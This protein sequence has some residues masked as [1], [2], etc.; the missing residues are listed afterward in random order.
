MELKEIHKD[1]ARME[2]QAVFVDYRRHPAL[3]A[4][5]KI[6]KCIRSLVHI[7]QAEVVRRMLALYMR[8]DGAFG[9]QGLIKM[10]VGR[11]DMLQAGPHSCDPIGWEMSDAYE[12][13]KVS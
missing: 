1:L 5:E 7:D 6:E 9:V 13:K 8:M 12:V 10:L 11:M 2:R 4:H 3:S